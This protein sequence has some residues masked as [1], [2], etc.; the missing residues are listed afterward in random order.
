MSTINIS[1]LLKERGFELPLYVKGCK[2]INPFFEN[3]TKEGIYILH[4]S[5]DTKYV[6]KSIDF[7]NRFKQHNINYNDIDAISF[8]SVATK[9]LDEVEQ[10]TI[11]FLEAEGIRLRNIMFSSFTYEKTP[12]YDLV[13]QDEQNSFLENINYDAFSGL[14]TENI[15]LRE[16]YKRRFSKFC[17]NTNYSS[18]IQFVREYILKTIPYPKRTEI[19]YWA[20]S[21]LPSGDNMV[22]YRVNINW[23]EV[24]TAYKFEENVIISFHLAESSLP[25]EKLSKIEGMNFCDHRYAPGGQD[26][27]NME[28]NSVGLALKLLDDVEVIKA[29][30]KLNLN[31][32]R[33][34]IC[35]YSRYHC[36]QIV[37][38]IFNH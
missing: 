25:I 11:A 20:I 3:T 13:S 23:Q 17:R 10:K 16:K 24:L 21:C 12:F 19:N 33:K 4:F 15:D 26:Q 35:A 8:K 28:T 31:L 27:V 18:L 37:D 30:K 38:E 5:D 29:C 1:I 6:G 36:L 7:V 34:G 2:D 9:R 32:M 22:L 14:R